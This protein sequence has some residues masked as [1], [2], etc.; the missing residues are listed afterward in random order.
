LSESPTC[1]ASPDNRGEDRQQL[2]RRVDGERQGKKAMTAEG[3]GGRGEVVAARC[4]TKF[5]HDSRRLEE[6]IKKTG[7]A[8]AHR[9]VRQLGPGH[10]RGRDGASTRIGC[11]PGR[12][13]ARQRS[14]FPTVSTQQRDSALTG[15]ATGRGRIFPTPL[16]WG[17]GSSI[18]RSLRAKIVS[19]FGRGRWHRYRVHTGSRAP[20]LGK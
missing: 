12:G 1:S 15:F 10:C 20:V 2:G 16:A 7:S 18:R 5:H 9:V 8:K 17:G 14:A 6:L 19:A 4:R 3:G 11:R 13:K